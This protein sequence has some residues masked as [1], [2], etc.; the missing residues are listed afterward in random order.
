MQNPLHFFCT[1]RI[2]CKASPKKLS[3]NLLKNCGI[4]E[5]ENG[6]KLFLQS[7]LSTWIEK[8]SEVETFQ[9][10]LP[11]IAHPVKDPE[12]TTQIKGKQ[13]DCH[14]RLDIGYSKPKLGASLLHQGLASI[15][16]KKVSFGQ[17]NL[18]PRPQPN[19]SAR[20]DELKLL[21]NQE[22]LPSQVWLY[23]SL[24]DI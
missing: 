2:H 8:W 24:S 16:K 3:E 10:A 21:L 14:Q 17:A 15:Q 6:W 22:R 9:A 4:S 13:P 1:K 11:T 19:S 20:M 18:E 23:T 12:I 7:H 5:N